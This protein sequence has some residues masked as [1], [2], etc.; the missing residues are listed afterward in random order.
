MPFDVQQ[1]MRI[2]VE[3]VGGLAFLK[4]EGLAAI[5]RDELCITAVPEAHV[6]EAGAVLNLVAGY[7]A[8]EKAVGDEE[9]VGMPHD[10][11][12]L[13]VRLVREEEPTSGFLGIFGRK[14]GRQRIVD[15]WDESNGVPWIAL[16]TLLLWQAKDATDAGDAEQAAALMEASLGLV[17]PAKGEV[18]D[19]GMPYNAGG[20]LAA[21]GLAELQPERR[22]SWLEEAF[23]R[24]TVAQVQTLG[25]T[26]EDLEKRSASKLRASS[27]TLLSAQLTNQDAQAGGPVVM[28]VG[29]L[30]AHGDGLLMDRTVLPKPLYEPLTQTHD[31]LRSE[32]VRALAAKVAAEWDPVDVLE[33]TVSTRELYGD[34]PMP[35][36]TGERWVV[37][38]R[39]LSLVLAHLGVCLAGGA[40][41]EDLPAV[42]DEPAPEG[43]A[44]RIAQAFAAFEE[45]K[46]QAMMAA[47]NPFG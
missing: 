10:G 14:P 4:T 9:L 1:Q 32:P 41:V 38:M 39:L 24:S 22:R 44:E 28:F 35:V 16:S 30:A 25:D 13:A 2:L 26:L 12:L 47:L 37:G 5:G 34:S 42:F 7:V 20:A 40:D 45:R 19:P 15:G 23:Q 31:A 6:R 18:P 8:N 17:T 29:P 3:P 27:L 43:A 36:E 11:G 33:A 46:S 21:L